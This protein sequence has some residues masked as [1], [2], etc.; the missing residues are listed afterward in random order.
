[1][2]V[3]DQK[4]DYCGLKSERKVGET[5]NQDLEIIERDRVGK[6]K[7]VFKGK[8]KHVHRLR[9]KPRG[10]RT[11]EDSGESSDNQESPLYTHIL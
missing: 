5:K 11:I 9:R 3:V 7:T 4:T 2:I 8:E 6:W 1:M 10:A